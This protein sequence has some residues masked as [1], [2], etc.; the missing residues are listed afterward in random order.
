[1][2]ADYPERTRVLEI[3]KRILDGTIYDCL[4][5]EFHEE[6]SLSGEYVPLRQ[7]RPSVRYGLARLV[8]EDSVA[9]LFSEAHFPAIESSDA[10]VRDAL[11][12]VVRDTKL[13]SVM[14]E[15]ALRG[16]VGSVAV[17]LRV[18]RGR[19]FFDV[20]ETLYLTPE[21][22]REA[23]DRLLRVTERYKVSGASLAA[24]GVAI[25]D[26]GAMYWFQ[27]VWDEDCEHW[28]EPVPVGSSATA[29]RDAERSTRHA[30]G[31]VPV[32]WVRNLPGGSGVDGSCTFR[33][34]IDTGIEIDY[35][36]SQAGRG[37]KYSS[38]PT[39]LIR[40]PAGLE[41]TMVRGA[42]NALVVS[43]KGDAKLLEIGGT[44]SQAV[45][46]YVRVLREFALESL[47]GNR[48]DPQRMTAP[49]S[50]RA[51]ELMNQG[52][53][54][55]ADNLR[56]SYGQGALLTLA[57]MVLR[58]SHVFALQVEGRELAPLNVNARLSL[59]WPD[60]YPDDA[61]DGQRKAETLI[62]LVG[63]A[64]MSRETA[65]RILASDYDI[66][67]VAGEIA[68]IRAEGVG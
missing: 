3:Y 45:I 4:P 39:L 36:L 65:L 24:Q 32:V 25:A 47:H 60:W 42:A 55:L 57:R 58:A 21:W 29:V 27:R 20:M 18:L 54:W 26:P 12:A 11:A 30:L 16:A 56:V 38:D 28:F 14:V 41:G 63:A 53:L 22:D 37:L 9:L 61:L 5:Y 48:A 6:R 66:E 31:F 23:P 51:I 52:L 34:A 62:S 19:V 64:Q 50:G 44:A 49:A 68:K 67:D 8:V 17:L 10:E 1:M 2:D 7:R 35:Q 15:T 40:E 46:E 59:R 33:N 43:E 13:N